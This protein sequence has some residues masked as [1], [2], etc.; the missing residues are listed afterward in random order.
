MSVLGRKTKTVGNRDRFHVDF[1][2]WLDLDSAERVVSVVFT[3]DQGTATVDGNVI[4]PDGQSMVFYLNGGT[5]GDQ[6]N[7]ILQQTTNLGTIRYDHYTIFVETNGGPTITSAND[8]LML[9]IVGPRGLT[10]PTGITGAPGTAS[11]TGSTGYTG[12]TGPTGMTGFG[13]TGVTG[14]TGFNGTTGGAGPTGATGVLYFFF[15]ADPPASPQVGWEWMDSDT[16]IT[17]RWIDDGDSQQWVDTSGS[18]GPTGPTGAGVTGPTGSTGPTGRTGPTGFDGTLGGTGPTGPT[19]RTGP[20]GFTGP[21]GANSG[22]AFSVHKNGTSQTGIVDSVETK[23]TWSTEVY[24]IGGFFASDKWTPPAGKVHMDAAILMNGDYATGALL[25]IV[26]YKNGASFKYSTDSG[27]NVFGAGGASI[28]ID[29]DA[30]GTDFY[31]MYVL[32]DTTT[33]TNT[34]NGDA[35]LTFWMG[36]AIGTGPLGPTGPTGNTGPL[37]VAS[38]AF[39]VHKNGTDQTGI[40]DAAYN[41]VTWSTEIYDTANEFASNTWTPAAGRV[42]MSAQLAVSGTIAAGNTIAVDIFKNGVSF[43]QGLTSVPVANT[44]FCA[45]S[46]DDDAN[47]TDTYDVRAF[48]DV[49]S[50]TGTVSGT[51]TNTFFMG[52]HV[53]AAGPTGPSGGPTGPT[54][55]PPGFVGFSAYKAADQTGVPVGTET[56]VTFTTEEFD[57]GSSYDA[58]N[59]KW[60][61][62]AGKVSMSA[63]VTFA[64][65]NLADQA[66]VYFQFYKNGAAYKAPMQIATS[67]T[68]QA[69]DITGTIIADANGTD[70]FEVFAFASSTGL[71]TLL[72]GANLTYFMGHVIGGAGPTGMTGPTGPTG[73]FGPTGTWTPTDASGAGLVLTSVSGFYSVIGDHVFASATFTYP[74]TAN[75]SSAKIGGLPFAPD[76]GNAASRQGQLTYTNSANANKILPDGSGATTFTIYTAAG[77][78]VTNANMSLT[79][80]WVQLVYRK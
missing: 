36:H 28:S 41:L 31:E 75:G 71:K 52:H 1:T 32:G 64:S 12:P 46:C 33:G 24:D 18:L 21:T 13:A 38:G 8:A 49:T 22:A 27:S 3:I 11:L 65:T 62:P 19:G 40:T 57:V 43:K 37:G 6:F 5:L 74:S 29:D 70:Y 73:V 63:T 77:A 76:A 68:T 20:T 7:V 60:T 35:K 34:L 9:S 67:G 55:A 72:G 4:A 51:A 61:P 39:S 17:Y 79:A 66:D 44:G 50:G 23:A 53:T 2:G 10:G 45:V 80:N 25:R 59:S 48:I 15:Q 47:G 30:N 54:G 16:G 42:H 56:K 14:P 26:I 58:P 69:Y 78:A